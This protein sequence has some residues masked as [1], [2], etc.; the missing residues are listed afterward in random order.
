MPWQPPV[1][2]PAP[3]DFELDSTSPRHAPHEEKIVLPAP[4]DEASQ[5][6]RFHS[7]VDDFLRNGA[8]EM[9]LPTAGDV[10]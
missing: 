8:D 2:P 5:S 4:I 9:R 7:A 6:A 1:R 10:V 3:S